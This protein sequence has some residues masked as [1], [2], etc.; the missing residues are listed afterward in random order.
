MRSGVRESTS[1]MLTAFTSGA[2]SRTALN[3][4]ISMV[5]ICAQFSHALVGLGDGAGELKQ[6]W[7]NYD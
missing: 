6:S 4:S 7:A 2:I 1:E 3:A 5:D